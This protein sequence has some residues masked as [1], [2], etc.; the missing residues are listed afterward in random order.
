MSSVVCLKA[1]LKCF[2]CNKPSVKLGSISSCILHILFDR[3]ILC[4][5]NEWLFWGL[6]FESKKFRELKDNCVNKPICI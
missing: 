3:N 2:L 4:I 5:E 1:I 6:F